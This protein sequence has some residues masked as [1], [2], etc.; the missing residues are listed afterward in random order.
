MNYKIIVTSITAINMIF[1]SRVDLLA[2]VVILDL[3]RIIFCRTLQY[4]L[5]KNICI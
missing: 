3:D 5:Q 2:M 1:L 4:S